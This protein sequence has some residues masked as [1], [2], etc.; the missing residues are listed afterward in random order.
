MKLQLFLLY[1]ISSIFCFAQRQKLDTV[2][3][4]N[5]KDVIE[6]NGLI[7]FKADTSLVTG[8]VIRFNK[9][10]EAKKYF[11]VTNGEPDNS[12]WIRIN[13]PFKKP[14]GL[15]LY[16][17]DEIAV[18][19]AATYSIVSGND[20]GFSGQAPNDTNITTRSIGF[21]DRQREYIKK[22]RSDMSVRK[23]IRKVINENQ[24]INKELIEQYRSDDEFKVKDNLV[25]NK[26]FAIREEFQE[27]DTLKFSER[28]KNYLKDSFWDKYYNGQLWSHEYFIEGKKEGLLKSYYF[29]GKKLDLIN[30]K[31]G[32]ENAIM[33][34]YHRN[35]HLMTKGLFKDGVQIG[36]WI[37]YDNNGKILRVERFD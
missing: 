35:G 29:Y 30:F 9:K 25:E 37:F 15:D 10:N 12:G 22:E 24:E 27:N 14:K 6:K 19:A 34:I 13:N 23:E 16:G 36:Q 26:K 21:I 8:K 32:K 31:N 3:T 20:I 1:F 5:F 28:F 17:L 7:F 33:E 4:V 11:M 2:Q 18:F